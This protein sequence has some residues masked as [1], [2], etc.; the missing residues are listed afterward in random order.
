MYK[1]RVKFQRNTVEVPSL[2]NRKIF[3]EGDVFSII[4][5]VSDLRRG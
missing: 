2:A 4:K 5:F 3:D 1:K